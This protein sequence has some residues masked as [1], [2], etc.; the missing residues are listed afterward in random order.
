MHESGPA[1]PAVP[2]VRGLIFDMDG[3]LVDSRL[4]FSAMRQEMELPAGMPILEAIRDMPPGPRRE[5]C[6]QILNRHEAEAIE[7]AVLIAGADRLAATL[8]ELALP[9][10]IL[11]RNAR[12]PARAMLTA[13]QLTSFRP[14]L[15]RED[16][17]AKPDP[18]GILKICEEW[19]FCP[20]EVVMVGD[21]RFD[22][23][24][25]RNAGTQTILL[26]EGDR[27]EFADLADFV[28]SSL[29]EMIPWILAASDP[30]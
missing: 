12:K 26:A 1:R 7:R 19:G 8:Q 9:H 10:A 20:E 29:D 11:T 25:G 4:D 5:M 30:N 15:A 2:R 18:A 16:A 23:E 24:A 14:V 13:L 17:P 6:C 3:T 27:P 21:F 22:I 28:I